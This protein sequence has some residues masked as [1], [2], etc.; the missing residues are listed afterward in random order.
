MQTSRT[1]NGGTTLYSMGGIILLAIAAV[2]AV[3]TKPSLESFNQNLN[4]E[5]RSE[6]AQA[7]QSK[8]KDGIMGAVMRVGCTVDVDACVRMLRSQMEIDEKDLIVARY[9][10]VLTREEEK[11]CLGVFNSWFCT[12]FNPR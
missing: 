7:L 1:A 4:T 11:N 2:A 9:V 6:V 3:M 12:G 5:L 8:Q 10:R